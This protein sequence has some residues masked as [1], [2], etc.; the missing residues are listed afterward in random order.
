MQCILLIKCS[1]NKFQILI[2]WIIIIESCDFALLEFFF[3]EKKSQC[4]FF[5]FA[6]L[7]VQ[8]KLLFSFPL[9]RVIAWKFLFSFE[10]LFQ[11]HIQT[12]CYL[13]FLHTVKSFFFA[14]NTNHIDIFQLNLNGNSFFFFE[15]FRLFF[16][17]FTGYFC[18]QNIEWDD[19]M[20]FLKNFDWPKQQKNSIHIWKIWLENIS[21]FSTIHYV[22]LEFLI[23]SW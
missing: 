5:C 4:F 1:W 20:F 15:F 21:F 6:S 8:G 17:N 16:E 3:P 2:Q 22:W 12:R 10:S 11:R 13:C 19:R 7:F 9:I 14:R 23:I 18:A